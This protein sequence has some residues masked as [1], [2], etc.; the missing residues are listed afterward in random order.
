GPSR[1]VSSAAGGGSRGQARSP[2]APAGA[3]G[4]PSS[5]FSRTRPR[6]SSCCPAGHYKASAV[7]RQRL[8]FRGL[9]LGAQMGLADVLPQRITI[10]G[11]GDGP[12]ADVVSYLRKVLD[13][14]VVVSLRIGSPRANRKPVLELL[15][16]D[17][18]VLGFA[19][20]GITGLT[21]ELVRAEAN[22]LGVLEAAG[23]TRLEVPRL[24]HHGQWRE[25]EV[26][27]QAPLRGSGRAVSP[28]AL[29]SAMAELA[30]AAGVTIKMV[31]R[32]DYWHG[33]R[34]RLEA[35]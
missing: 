5:W 3:G 21:R 4:R 7:G 18:G 15:S 13:Q 34:S 2:A 8:R 1:R 24:L 22:A 19:K 14:D 23:L 16:P 29:T 32:S 6:A 28:A 10:E 20:V 9:A 33:L 11:S 26:L 17:G 30:T 31:G 12:D 35:C 25:H 27:V